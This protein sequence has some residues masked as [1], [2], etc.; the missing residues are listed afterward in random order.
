MRSSDVGR[1]VAYK[2]VST[3]GSVIIAVLV[4]LV[5]SSS[6][7]ASGDANE[8][9]CPLAT[10]S[11]QGFRTYL[12][13]CRAYEMVTPPFKDGGDELRVRAVSSDGSRVIISSLGAFAGTEGDPI[14]GT[15]GAVY[16]L[17]RSGS[18]WVAYPD[19]PPASLSPNAK[20]FGVSLD[21]TK[22]LWEVL[23]SAKSLY[24]TDLDLRE[25]DGK[26]VEIGPLI[27]PAGEAGPPADD[28]GGENEEVGFAGA[29]NDLSHVLYNIRAVNPTF[30][31]PGDTTTPETTAK[32]LYEY[33]GTGNT[34]PLL[35]GVNSEGLIS[36]CG[37]ALGSAGL[38]GGGDTYNG[39]STNG[40]IVFF[41]AIGHD[42]N[43]CNELTKA[44]EVSELYARLDQVQTIAISEPLHSQCS[45]CKT[46]V[47]KPAIFQGA[48][49]DGSKVFF[50]TEQE[51]FI[52]DTTTN[53]Y[54]YDFNNPTGE[55][56]IRVSV[57]SRTPEVEGVMR[58]SEDGSH[59]YFV[60]KAVLTTGPNREGLTP[61][62]GGDNLYAFERDVTYPTGR[63]TFVGTLSENDAQDWSRGDEREAQTTP[64]GRFLVFQSSANLTSGDTSSMPQI[65]EY[66]ALREKLVRIST[67][68]VG[69]EAGATN[70]N[71]SYS[72]ISSQSFGEVS[73]PS[74]T[75]THLAVS[76]DGLRILFSSSGALTGGAEKA[77]AAGAESVYEY[78]SVG[79]IED[80]DVYLVSDGMNALSPVVI[81]LDA[82][83]DDAFFSTADPLLSSDADTQSDIYDARVDG[84]FQTPTTPEACG[85]DGCQGVLSAPP[86][87]GLPGSISEPGGGNLIVP[88]LSRKPESVLKHKAKRR[89]KRKRKQGKKTNIHTKVG[90]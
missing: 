23:G 76:T 41:T 2:C 15:A 40:E 69:Y 77:A 58:V 88:V 36:N 7:L 21:A 54:E 62:P 22:E 84:G 70:A 25:P 56:I 85:G 78:R 42:V 9:A 20:L 52:N 29:S 30:L 67:G 83:G 65:F 66:D 4:S 45:Q 59:V 35:V 63:L 60:A 55:K 81:G 61:T 71:A 38:E 68:A 89:A 74:E 86:P 12:P 80:G 13:D 72:L 43:G 48:S 10:E 24:S 39:I 5:A 87:L 14:N 19:T 47:R 34:D 3:A 26:F 32:S 6:V 28:H 16:E 31:W 53:L 8:P 1:G 90:R 17:T 46:A 75:A 79:S 18:G 49:E 44:P 82:A 50:L 64:D 37:T 33:V 73:A 11:S 51:L 27:P 57:G